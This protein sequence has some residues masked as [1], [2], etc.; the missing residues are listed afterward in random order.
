MAYD[1]ESQTALQALIDRARAAGAD[2]SEASIAGRESLSVEVRMGALE[3]V[4]REEARSAALRAFVGKRQAAASTTDLSEKGLAELAERVVAM[5]KAAPEDAYCGLLEAQYRAT[6]A[7]P[8]LEQADTVR[9][10]SA[11][12]QAM[13]LA[14]EAAS[15]SVEGVENS[16]GGGAS[17][18]A[19]AF[20]HLTSDGFVG[21]EQ[22]TAY[23]LGAQPIAERDGKMERDYEYRTKRFFADLPGAED[24]GRIAGDRAV[25]RLGSRK[26]PSGHAG[27]LF[28]N[29]LASRLI[30]PLL[31]GMSGAA[32][33]RGASFVKDKLGQRV[34][35]ETFQIFEDP[36]LKRGLASRAFD[37]EGGAVKARALIEDGVITTWFL[38]AATGRQLGMAPTGHATHG[39]GGPPGASA[40]NLE[41]KPGVDTP[42]ALMKAAGKGVIVTEMFSPA[43]NMNTGDWSVGVSGVWFENGEPAYPVSEITIAGNLLEMYDRLIA[44]SDLERRGAIAIPSLFVDDLA[45]GGV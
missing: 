14:C 15:L 37:G 34:L 18:E 8:E 1:A 4:E 11:Q 36:F 6:G 29:R 44:A 38:N 24:I 42:E 7:A 22:T 25:A 16:G 27:V 40:S 10:D 30:G 41:I 13:A 32:V 23:S 9:P 45:I 2:A 28:E 3:G 39:H 21:A 19:S 17:W 12:L 20:A 31:S 35:P 43:L 33:A 26:L 5:A